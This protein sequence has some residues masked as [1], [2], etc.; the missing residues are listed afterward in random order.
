MGDVRGLMREMKEEGMLNVKE[1]TMKR[2]RKGQFTI[3][4]MGEQLQNVMKL[5]P[6]DRVLNMLPGLPAGMIPKG[7]EKEGSERLKRM[8]IL[9]N[10]MTDAELDG[11]VVMDD[12]RL[13]RCCIGA[14]ILPEEGA[15]FMQYY[16]Q[17]EGMIGKMGKSPLLRGR[18][19]HDGL[20]VDE[21]MMQ[22][23]Q[24]NPQA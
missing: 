7:S 24:R 16:K 2:I 1:D 13:K 8:M 6:L 17:M 19:S 22:Q 15:I 20:I 21:K 3:R 9:M 10:S 23:M 11:E 18:Q 5:G 14:G 12:R 4:D